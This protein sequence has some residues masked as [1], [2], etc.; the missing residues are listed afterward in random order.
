MPTELDLGIAVFTH[1][2]RNDLLPR[3]IWMFHKPEFVGHLV[4]ESPMEPG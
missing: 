1:V 4:V 2:T 3:P